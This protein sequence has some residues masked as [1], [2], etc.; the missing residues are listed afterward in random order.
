MANKPKILAWDLETSFNILASFRLFD[1][2]GLSIPHGNI[3]QER[4]I[5]CASWSL[6]GES[7]VYSA[8]VA[9]EKPDDDKFV[10]ELLHDVLS[11]VD[12]I[13]HHYGDRFD[14]PYFNARAIKHG[15]KPI[16]PIIQ[17]DT[18][19]IAKSKFLFNSNRLDYLGQFLGLGKK[20]KTDGDLWLGC[21]R[22]DKKALAKMVKYNRQDVRLLKRV[23]AKLRPYVP[24]KVNQ[25]LFGNPDACPSCGSR[26]TQKRGYDYTGKTKFQRHQCTSCGN[27]FRGKRVKAE[28]A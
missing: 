2:A 18:K 25:Q 3:L 17:I 19:A 16:P 14:L 15:L 28:A 8:C 12:A 4:N 11:N 9:P 27:W 24:T 7:Q 1:R 10:V 21:L 5:I 23:F 6:I 20:I 26:K 22:G 13:V